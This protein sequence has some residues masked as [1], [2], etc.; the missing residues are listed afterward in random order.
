MA[1]G[2]W[3]KCVLY[4]SVVTLVNI[5]IF[6]YFLTSFTNSEDA[7][8]D[9]VESSFEEEQVL[10]EQVWPGMIQEQDS[11]RNRKVFLPDEKETRYPIVLWWNPFT[12]DKRLVKTCKKGSTERTCLF[13]QSRTEFNNPLTAA[14]MF[15]A[16]QMKWEDMPLPRGPNHMWAIIQEESPKNN[17][18]LAFEEGISLFNMT[19]TPSRHSTYPLT[20]QY[21]PSLE[22]LRKPPLVPIPDKGKGD[23]GIIMYLHSDCGTPS[24]RDTYVAELMKHIQVDSYGACLH[25]RDLPQHLVDP[26]TMDHQDV[27]KLQSQYKFSL[28]FENAIC[29]DYITEKLWRPLTVGSVPV[30]RGSPT[31]R[32]W[33][34]DNKSAIIAEEFASPKELAEFLKSLDADD[35]KYREYLAWKDHGITNQRLIKEMRERGYGHHDYR[36]DYTSHFE[37]QVCNRIF[38][39]REETA[40]GEK[41][42]ISIANHS[43]WDCP[44]L[45]PAFGK[46][47]DRERI[48]NSQLSTNDDLQFWMQHEECSG[49]RAK[50]IHELIANNATAEEVRI[51]S[52]SVQFGSCLFG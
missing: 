46:P 9:A 42:T 1:N 15:Y 34:P 16:S 40:R 39:M 4:S 41:P 21:L 23:I 29:H 50:F 10:P 13:T 7:W 36:D 18:I 2:C 26:L 17:W 11:F 33:L 28:A 48:L 35:S 8:H 47:E 32:D 52:T 19:A 31:V 38:D 25:N 20:T 12:P 44:L 37:C 5:C 22:V 45:Y 14:F 6:A 51:K 3:R 49:K 27:L 30:V 24:D 43:H